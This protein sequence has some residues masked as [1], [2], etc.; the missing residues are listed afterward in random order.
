[1][2]QVCVIES[3]VFLSDGWSSTA[4]TVPDVACWVTIARPEVGAVVTCWAVEEELRGG[5]HAIAEAAAGIVETGRPDIKDR[6]EFGV[7]MMDRG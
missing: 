2:P 4:F 6:D 5:A 1:M 7:D 3:T